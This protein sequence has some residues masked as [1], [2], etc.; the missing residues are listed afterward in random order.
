MAG[1][2]VD[3]DQE[4][5]PFFH[6]APISAGVGSPASSTGRTGS[7]MEVDEKTER[8]D[9]VPAAAPPAPPGPPAPSSAAESGSRVAPDAA[10]LEVATSL[11][12]NLSG[13]SS[14]AP[15][16]SAR[17]P[18]VR[19][20]MASADK[21]CARAMVV[22]W[23]DGSDARQRWVSAEDPLQS[24]WF[25][26]EK[27]LPP[28]ANNI[29]VQFK[30]KGP[31]KK[32]D[33]CMVDRR[34]SC[35]WV[36]LGEGRYAQEIICF[37]IGSQHAVDPIDA[38]FELRGP[39]H[40]CFV[41]RAWNASRVGD[42]EEWEC[43]EDEQSR[44][45]T[46][47]SPVTL[48]AA[49][50]AALHSSCVSRDVIFDIATCRLCAAALAL[51]DVHRETLR[52]LRGL[53][54]SCTNQWLRTNMGTTLS[55]GLLVVAVPTV[56]V[57]PPVGIG[58]AIAGGVTG[59]AAIGGGTFQER[60]S[61]SQLRRQLSK[62]S[63]NAFVVAELLRDWLRAGKAAGQPYQG[64]NGE[65]L[66][67]TSRKD[68]AA[69]TAAKSVAYGVA[70]LGDEA[71]LVLP[72]LGPV[73]VA[74]GAVLTTGVAIHGW[75][76]RRFS[77]KEV[78][79]KVRELKARL[80]FFQCLLARLGKLHCP[81]C[82]SSVTDTDQMRCC[83]DSL[84]YC[85]NDCLPADAVLCPSCSGPL[86][87][88]ISTIGSEAAGSESHDTVDGSEADPLEARRSVG[89]GFISQKSRSFLSGFSA[90]LGTMTRPSGPSPESDAP[91]DWAL[92]EMTGLLERLS[93]ALSAPPESFEQVQLVRE[94]LLE[95]ETVRPELEKLAAQVAEHPND[96]VDLALSIEDVL[97]RLR[98]LND[99]FQSWS[100]EFTGALE[101]PGDLAPESTVEVSETATLQS[102]GGAVSSRLQGVATV[103]RGIADTAGA[104]ATASAAAV[105]AFGE[106]ASLRAS[107]AASRVG[108][109]VLG[110]AAA[111]TLR[112]TRERTTPS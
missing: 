10:D 103:G 66:D 48:L 35:S 62:D 52:A 20:R 2:S 85:H 81:V 91:D 42:P 82:L 12:T 13:S 9:S 34:D 23:E 77:Q 75:T 25:E 94:L 7:L 56:I 39:M 100:A 111:A 89:F 73:G 83:S 54:A 68:S 71:A 101:C 3:L 61:L 105:T 50:S 32:W 72:A 67:G 11:T 74:L 112:F 22:E 49:D 108:G 79:L 58:L 80:V 57:V 55:A 33:V 70:L 38:V 69:S 86:P 8:Y 29:T 19:L 47:E 99:E 43:W 27:L 15:C 17:G 41:G 78:R 104:K 98:T 107:T 40:R 18:P 26:A 21:L 106:S 44:P 84:H 92:W 53:D 1:E 93:G 45:P 65:E 24:G 59:G 5:V 76:T 109:K 37:R 95:C 60:W 63:W 51:L 36:L 14:V 16:L 6:G 87:S 90:R 46:E 28:T 97:D 96:G 64:T 30:V 102:H 110:V 4:G 31:R 88:Q